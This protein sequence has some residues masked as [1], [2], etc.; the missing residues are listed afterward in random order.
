MEENESKL[1]QPRQVLQV[2]IKPE[3]LEKMELKAR[4]EGYKSLAEKVR[5]MLIHDLQIN[6]EH[7]PFRPLYY[8]GKVVQSDVDN[9]MFDS[10]EV[11]D[12]KPMDWSV[13]PSPLIPPH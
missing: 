3:L 4:D 11:N 2:Y 9:P 10:K 7:V 5:S 8:K 13:N 6:S 1:K 12:I